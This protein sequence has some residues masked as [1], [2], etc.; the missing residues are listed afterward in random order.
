M[1]KNIIIQPYIT[2]KG[3]L[4]QNQ[5]Q[6]VFRAG[7]RANKIEIKKEIENLYKVK[8]EKVRVLNKP[9]KTKFFRARKRSQP[10][11]KKAIVKLKKGEKL[12]L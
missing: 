1:K 5:N 11:F 9:E 12:E 3:T 8:V 2:E 4:L 7:E 10:G 6:Y